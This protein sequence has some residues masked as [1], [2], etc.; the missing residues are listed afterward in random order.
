MSVFYGLTAPVL[1]LLE[2]GRYRRGYRLYQGSWFSGA[3][4]VCGDPLHTIGGG[5]RMGMSQIM[6]N[7]FSPLCH[8][9]CQAHSRYLKIL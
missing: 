6:G 9:E 5:S 8:V 3:H 4:S 1:F 7:I 2:T